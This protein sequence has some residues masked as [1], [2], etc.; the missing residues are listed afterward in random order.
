MFR[1]IFGGI[2]LYPIQPAL[3]IGA[4]AEIGIRLRLLGGMSYRVIPAGVTG[5]RLAV[6]GPDSGRGIRPGVKHS[7]S[8]KVVFP[9]EK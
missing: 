1:V 7:Q 3:R 4:C 9:A 5:R 2:G 6:F 8:G